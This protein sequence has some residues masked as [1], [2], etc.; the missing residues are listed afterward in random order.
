MRKVNLIF[1]EDVSETKWKQGK[2]KILLKC[3]DKA[4]KEI[5]EVIVDNEAIIYNLKNVEDEMYSIK[6]YLREIL[7]NSK[8]ERNFEKIYI[9]GK[10]FGERKEEERFVYCETE[11]EIEFLN[12]VSS[13]DDISQTFY[14]SSK[15]SEVKFSFNEG[16]GMLIYVKLSD[17]L[18]MEN[19]IKKETVNT[20]DGIEYVDSKEYSVKVNE[21]VTASSA[22]KWIS[23]YKFNGVQTF[24]LLLKKAIIKK[25]PKN[26]LTDN[27]N[28]IWSSFEEFE[29]NVEMT[30]EMVYVLSNFYYSPSM[31]FDEALKVI[32]EAIKNR[33]I[34][35]FEIVTEKGSLTFDPFENEKL[36]LKSENGAK[37][38][39]AI[40]D[41]HKIS[42]YVKEFELIYYNKSKDGY[43]SRSQI[44]INILSY[45][46]EISI[47]KRTFAKTDFKYLRK[48]S[49]KTGKE[50]KFKIF[51]SYDNFK[52]DGGTLKIK[53]NSYYDD[54]RIEEYKNR[55]SEA[56]QYF[57]NVE[58]YSD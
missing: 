37:I 35:S 15:N 32:S 22:L 10:L 24:V 47:T 42:E 12:F 34:G 14:N 51:H 25:M 54:E 46:N 29:N 8:I 48:L 44:N 53:V 31:S 38:N 1:L 6:R 9:N 33:R 56:F 26:N 50:I 41:F 20:E 55:F 27:C 13:F 4:E 5:G 30:P 16:K 58:T 39:S 43:Y 57:E 19:K 45:E 7:K 36:V 18:F 11:N 2:T 28:E 40:E 23:S 52:I 17:K 3:Q 21:I 49:E